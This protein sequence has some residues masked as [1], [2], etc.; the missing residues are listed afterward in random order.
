LTHTNVSKIK[1][2]NLSCRNQKKRRRLSLKS[3]ISLEK[4]RM[5]KISKLASV[6]PKENLR[7]KKALPAKL[8]LMPKMQ[9]R[10]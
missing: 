3:L 4:T 8:S 6:L 2:L 7:A 1:K 9:K 5:K 10:T